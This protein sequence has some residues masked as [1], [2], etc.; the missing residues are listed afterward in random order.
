MTTRTETIAREVSERVAAYEREE[1]FGR[2]DAFRAPEDVEA[3][4]D[5]F[6]WLDEVD[7][8]LSDLGDDELAEFEARVTGLVIDALFK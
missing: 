2:D 4:A 5:R 6:G 1:G 7:A 8:D 3:Y